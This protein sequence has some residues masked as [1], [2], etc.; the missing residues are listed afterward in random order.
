MQNAVKQEFCKS[1]V[2]KVLNGDFTQRSV[3]I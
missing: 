2:G 1:E 3:S